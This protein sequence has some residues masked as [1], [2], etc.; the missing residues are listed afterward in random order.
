[1]IGV[2]PD[3]ADRHTDNVG[4]ERL[5]RS[6]HLAV[7]GD[8]GAERATASSNAQTSGVLENL[9]LSP[10]DC[11]HAR[12]LIDNGWFPGSGPRRMP[13]WRTIPSRS[14]VAR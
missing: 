7:G 8:G 13:S 2:L 5:E 1:M 6:T 4:D 10:K 14:G 3:G 12:R 11:E 9:D